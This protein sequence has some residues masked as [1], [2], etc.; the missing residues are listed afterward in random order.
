MKLNYKNIAI[1]FGIVSVGL[2]SLYAI[3]ASSTENKAIDTKT[4]IQAEV[5]PQ[6]KGEDREQ[7]R[8]EVQQEREETKAALTNSPEEEQ[9]SGVVSDS[10]AASESN[11]QSGNLP[12]SDTSSGSN[13]G[14][15]KDCA[16][17]ATHAEAQTFYESAG[18]GDPHRLDRDGDGSA[19]ET[20]P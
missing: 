14:G 15:D 9:Q 16:D 12:N 13:S 8:E 18:A 17:F 6:L 2:G 1:A 4:N 7:L 19:C 5:A 20:L 10:N 3:G 11:T